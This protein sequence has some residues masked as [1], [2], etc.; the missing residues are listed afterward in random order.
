MTILITTLPGDI[1]AHAVRW[2]IEQK[3]GASQILYPADL[4]AGTEWCFDPSADEL[5]IGRGGTS[6]SV[7]GSEIKTVWNR[8]VPTS[9]PIESLNSIEERAASESE[10]SAMVLGVLQNFEIGRFVVNPLS[11]VVRAERKASQFKVARSVGFRTPRTIISNNLEEIR[12]FYE[13]CNDGMAYKPLLTFP[14]VRDGVI[15]IPQTQIIRSMST[16]SGIDVQ[17]SPGIYQEV[18]RRRSEIRATIMGRSVFAWTKHPVT[19]DAFREIDW[20]PELGPNAIHE[21]FEMP[22]HLKNKCFAMLDFFGLAYGCFDIAITE[23]N[24]FVLF[25]LNPS[26]QFLWGD[27]LGVNLNQLD[28]FASFLLGG[29]VDFVYRPDLGAPTFANYLA[30]NDFEADGKAELEGHFGNLN[31]YHF[32]KACVRMAYS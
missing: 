28:A 22:E 12:A 2:A 24:E 26:G 32:A 18:V 23:E 27:D 17:L 11:S 14:W 1:H 15:S 8:R 31:S 30:E 13:Q 10:L 16:F 7:R 29:T 25:E 5:K 21:Y 3:G 20:R 6:S 19:P 9:F 4:A